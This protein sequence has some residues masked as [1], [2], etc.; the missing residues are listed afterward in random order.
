MGNAISHQPA[1]QDLLQGVVFDLEDP[2]IFIIVTILSIYGYLLMFFKKMHIFKFACIFL[3][4]KPTIDQ[5]AAL[6]QTSYSGD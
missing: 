4:Y 2:P 6:M 3:F 1:L 5:Q